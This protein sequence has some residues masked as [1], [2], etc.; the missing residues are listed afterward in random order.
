MAIKSGP[1]TISRNCVRDGERFVLYHGNELVTVKNTSAEAKEA[2]S[3]LFA[4][5]AR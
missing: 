5:G 3:A 4:A 2:A 1:F